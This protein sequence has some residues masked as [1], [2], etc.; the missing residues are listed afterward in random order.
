MDIKKKGKFVKNILIM[1]VLEIRTYEGLKEKLG[2]SLAKDLFSL[3]DEKTIT[4][5][6]NIN[7]SKEVFV[8][9]P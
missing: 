8:C 7:L 4:A 5:K 1:T 6:D 9:C 3:L 2:E